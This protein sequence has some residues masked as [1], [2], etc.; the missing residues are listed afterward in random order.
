[1]QCKRIEDVSKECLQ[2]ST[3][4]T[5]QSDAVQHLHQMA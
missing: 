2:F 4:A 3:A 5:V 1:M